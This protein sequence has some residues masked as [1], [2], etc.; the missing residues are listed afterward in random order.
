MKKGLIVSLVVIV[1]L[2]AAWIV[3]GSGSVQAAPQDDAPQIISFTASVTQ[4]DR[5]EL[6]NRTARIPVAWQAINRPVLANLVFEQIMPDGSAIN[7]ELPRVI[8]WV[9]SSGS[10]IAAP[11]LPP[12]TVNSIRLR[13]SLVHMFTREVYDYREIGL[14]IGN[15]SQPSGDAQPVITSFVAAYTAVNALDLANGTARVPVSWVTVN[16][17]I[18]ANLVF[19]QVLPT[20]QVVNVE[21]PRQYPW[22][23]SSGTGTA[24]PVWPGEGYSWL[25]LRVRL[26]DVLDGRLYSEAGLTLTINQEV[27]PDPVITTFATDGAAV[28][29]RQLQNRTAYVPVYWTVEYRPPNSNLVFEQVM[30][31]GAVINVE[32]PRAEPMVQSS[33]RGVVRPVMAAGHSSIHLQLR[34]IDLSSGATLAQQSLW[35]PV[36]DITGPPPTPT[37]TPQ[38]SPPGGSSAARID[39]FTGQPQ[40][41]TRGGSVTLQ[42][43]VANAA[44]IN[45]YRIDPRTS[46]RLEIIAPEDSLPHSG[47]LQYGL[48]GDVVDR[49]GFMLTARDVQEREVSAHLIIPL[50]CPYPS[51]L[52]AY[53]PAT[54]TQT[55]GAFQAFERGYMIWLASNQIYVLFNGGAWDLYHDAY[56]E[57]ETIPIAETPPQ[58][59]VAPVRGFGKLWSRYPAVRQGLGWGLQE[60]QGYTVTLETHPVNGSSS[61]GDTVLALL[62]GR[63]VRLSQNRRWDFDYS[64]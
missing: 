3:L 23:A 2:L 41:A 51:I 4:V 37:W 10:G 58:G 33:G 44:H 50:V 6:A 1:C 56:V 5:T 57:G 9:A 11:Q 55:Q 32:L 35:L 24:A 43:S 34:V 30:P 25:R 14:P 20:G 53:C 36:A 64:R 18:T 45:I 63:V 17:P 15:G 59:L 42:W 19:E 38:P 8:P 47:A 52:T 26:V 54:Q 29:R 22:V 40:P 61:P 27:T 39:S 62:D 28:D 46:A 31:D 12:G 7:V 49:A 60:E 13:V 48:P 16:R 21:L